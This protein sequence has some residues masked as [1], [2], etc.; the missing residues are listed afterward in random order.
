M[1]TGT[2]RTYEGKEVTTRDVR[3]GDPGYDKN[4]AQVV[5]KNKDGSPF[6]GGASEKTVARSDVKTS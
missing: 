4:K 3:E 2:S 6:A 1:G 5:V